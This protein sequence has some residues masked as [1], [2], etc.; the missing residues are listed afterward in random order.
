LASF[1]NPPSIAV[2]AFILGHTVARDVTSRTDVKLVNEKYRY[3]QLDYIGG[4]HV[5]EYKLTINN[6]SALAFKSTEEAVVL[7]RLRD[8]ILAMNLTLEQAVLTLGQPHF[9]KLEF[10]TNEKVK[11]TVHA[12]VRREKQQSMDESVIISNLKL[13]DK[14]DWH[15][16][17][18]QGDKIKHNLAK[19]LR[20]YEK[21]Y[22]QTEDEEFFRYI[23]NGI[24]DSINYDQHRDFDQF[25]NELSSLANVAKSKAA[26]W[27]RIYDRIKHPDVRTK[28]PALYLQAIGEIPD[29]LVPMRQAVNRVIIERL[30]TIP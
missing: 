20:L 7:R 1:I 14:F 24:E 8:I 6:L 2:Y 18:Q 21:G 11:E 22:K 27:R 19:A 26:Q 4:H 5:T 16:E 9:P 3:F 15:I 29:E 17:D 25:D 13:I 30:K 23:F 28:Q 12:I 10:S